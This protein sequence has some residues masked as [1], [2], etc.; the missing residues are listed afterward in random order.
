MG[1]LSTLGKIGGIVAAPFTGGASLIPTALSM[2][3]DIG[4]TLGKQQ[5]GAASGR[6]AQEVANQGRDRTAIDLYQAQQGAQNQAR[7]L[8]LKTKSFENEN[9]GTTGKQALISALLSGNIDPTSISGGKASGGLLAALKA[10]PDAIAAMRNMHGQADKAQMAVPNFAGGQL[11]AAPQMSTPQQIDKGGWLSTLANIGQIAGAVGS[12]LPGDKA[13]LP[14][15]APPQP[16]MPSNVPG[17]VVPPM[18]LPKKHI[19]DEDAYG[20]WSNR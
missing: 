3:G 8:D 4:S 19:V 7:E 15:M 9:R 13:S 18:T 20:D 6:Q 17:Q 1:W 14:Y 2:A 5:Q 16:G 11:L 10:N 12:G